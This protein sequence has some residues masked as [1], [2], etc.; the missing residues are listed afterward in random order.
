[1]AMFF[2]EQTTIGAGVHSVIK[3]YFASEKIPASCFVLFVRLP[4]GNYCPSLLFF[5]LPLLRK[6]G[7]FIPNQASQNG[8]FNLSVFQAAEVP[9]K[10][11]L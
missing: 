11:L 6:E 8:E 10:H 4:S 2:L 9:C 5:A 3:I 1:M 7:I